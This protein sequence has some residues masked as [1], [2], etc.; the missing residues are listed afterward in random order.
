MKACAV[1]M[2]ERLRKKFKSSFV[3]ALR[4]ILLAL[5]ITTLFLTVSLL[6]WADVVPDFVKTEKNEQMQLIVAAVLEIGAIGSGISVLM[7]YYFDYKQIRNGVCPI[8]EVTVLRFEFY[9]GGDEATESY[10]YPVL[11]NVSSGEILKLKLDEK[12]EI[13]QH[14]LLA[15]LPRTR[16]F[17]F[18][19]VRPQDC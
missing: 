9:S 10:W 1:T 3:T 15:I 12:V 4:W 5:A 8:T 6:S 17:V 13:G 18:Q 19:I 7:L 14:L 2:Q 11:E 16:V